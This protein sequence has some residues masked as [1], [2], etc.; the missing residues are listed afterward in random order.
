MYKI[1]K[2]VIFWSL[3][4]AALLLPKILDFFFLDIK[5]VLHYFSTYETIRSVWWCGHYKG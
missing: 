2:I 3:Q 4:V 5:I 1:K